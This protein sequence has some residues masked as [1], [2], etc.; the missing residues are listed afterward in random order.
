MSVGTA[1]VPDP[2]GF[3]SGP[4]RD[5]GYVNAVAI[6][7]RSAPSLCADRHWAVYGVTGLP[8]RRAPHSGSAGI[9]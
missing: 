8:D 6:G 3:F 7:V 2:L 4:M 1:D 5:V 9:G